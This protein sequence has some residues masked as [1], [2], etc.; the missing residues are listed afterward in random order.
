MKVIVVD[1][2]YLI[3]F[4]LLLLFAFINGK[5]DSKLI[6]SSVYNVVCISIIF[7][8]YFVFEPLAWILALFYFVFGTDDETLQEFIL[9]KYKNQRHLLLNMWLQKLTQTAIIMANFSAIF[10]MKK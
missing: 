1:L 7:A 4:F 6:D 8:S 9:Q 3:S 5:R 2:T 10:I